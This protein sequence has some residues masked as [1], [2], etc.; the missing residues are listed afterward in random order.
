[1]GSFQTT[2]VCRRRLKRLNRCCLKPKSFF[3]RPIT[4]ILQGR[5]KPVNP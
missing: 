3:R 2:S 1:M 4:I 5:L